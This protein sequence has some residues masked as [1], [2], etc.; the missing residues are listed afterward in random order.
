MKLPALA[1]AT[2]ALGIACGVRMEVIPRG[3]SSKFVALLLCVAVISLLIGIVSAWHS[4]LV[5]AGVASLVCWGTLAR[6]RFAFRNSR[7]DRIIF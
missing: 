6:P 5:I 4:R 2:A 1:I 7:D 3:S